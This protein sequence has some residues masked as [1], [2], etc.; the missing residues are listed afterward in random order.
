MLEE[1]KTSHENNNKSEFQ[2]LKKELSDKERHINS[3]NLTIDKMKNEII[4]LKNKISESDKLREGNL[5]ELILVKDNRHLEAVDNFDVVEEKNPNLDF[6]SWNLNNE[7]V[8]NSNKRNE[9]PKDQISNENHYLNKKFKKYQSKYIKFKYKYQELKSFLQIFAQSSFVQRNHREEVSPSSNSIL[10][11][12]KS[13]RSGED[14]LSTHNKEKKSRK[15]ISNA[16]AVTGNS[17]EIARNKNE[18]DTQRK[19]SLNRINS[20]DIFEKDN[21][22][23]IGHEI[24]SVHNEEEDEVICVKER[25]NK[26]DVEQDLLENEFLDLKEKSQ[27]KKRNKKKSAKTEKFVE[28]AKIEK[29]EKNAK[30]QKSKRKISYNKEVSKN[31]K[32]KFKNIENNSDDSFSQLDENKNVPIS[33]EKYNPFQIVKV[34]NKNEPQRH[35]INP[36]KKNKIKV[37]DLD[38][39]I[40]IKKEIEIQLINYVNSIIVGVTESGEIQNFF[41]TLGSTW[42][43]HEK[44]FNILEIIFTNPHKIDLIKIIF[45]LQNLHLYELFSN[46]KEFIFSHLNLIFSQTENFFISKQISIEEKRF[47]INYFNLEE[48]FDLRNILT[49]HSLTSII[50][51]IQFKKLKEHSEF[52]KFLIIDLLEINEEKISNILNLFTVLTRNQNT[53]IKIENETELENY[54][55]NF[56]KIYFMQSFR[57]NVIS[58]SLAEFTLQLLSL[59]LENKQDMEFILQYL[60][61]LLEQIDENIELR[62]IKFHKINFAVDIR[63]LEIFQIISLLLKIKNLEWVSKNIFENFLWSSFLKSKEGNLKRVGIIFYISYIMSYSISKDYKCEDENTKNLINWVYAIFDPKFN[64]QMISAYDKI[65]ALSGFIDSHVILIDKNVFAIVKGVIE[66]IIQENG[67]EIFPEDFVEKMKKLSLYES[68]KIINK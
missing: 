2:K 14:H 27:N 1:L 48:S 38:Q 12:N 18:Y 25:N 66:K 35:H 53:L 30:E 5:N 57:K 54:R 51:A 63:Y 43:S 13:K 22:S 62:E 47:F 49:P 29:K 6:S 56:N 10:L 3:Q 58:R 64:A 46:I 55:M 41:D 32:K 34:D 31:K 33:E 44:I 15:K 26:M 59:R 45:F 36:I 17:L 16:S 19:T 8:Y 65:A 42:T 50:L 11:K 39:H 40:N 23:L 24:K 68:P 67:I 9:I 60:N 7:H 61:N 28:N 37:E 4:E 52:F 21:L 20:E